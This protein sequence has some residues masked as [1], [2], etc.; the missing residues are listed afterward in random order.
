ME[1]GREDM[2]QVYRDWRTRPGHC[3]V[4]VAVTVDTTRDVVYSL[5]SFEA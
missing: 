1:E 4:E 2:P 5:D 3:R